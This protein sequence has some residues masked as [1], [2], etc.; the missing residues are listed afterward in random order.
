MSATMLVRF[1]CGRIVA[2]EAQ[3]IGKKLS[4]AVS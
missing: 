1:L 3:Q 2:G 4:D